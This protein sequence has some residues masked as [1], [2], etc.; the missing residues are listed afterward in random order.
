MI[1]ASR[2]LPLTEWLLRTGV[3]GLNLGTTRDDVIAHGPTDTVRRDAIGD[4]AAIHQD[5]VQDRISRA[6]VENANRACC[7]RGCPGIDRVIDDDIVRAAIHGITV[8]KTD[9]VVG[10]VI[11][12]VVLDNRALQSVAID[13]IL[14]IA[15]DQ[16]ISDK[17][18]CDLRTSG[19]FT[20][21]NVNS[22]IAVII[23]DIPFNHCAVGGASDVYSVTGGIASN[24]ARD[25]IPLNQ[26]II[27]VVG[28]NAEATNPSYGVVNDAI[29]VASNFDPFLA[30][31]AVP[32]L[33]GQ[34]GDGDVITAGFKVDA[35]KRFVVAR[36]NDDR[37]RR[38]IGGGLNRD[39][40]AR[41]AIDRAV[42]ISRAGW[43]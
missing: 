3:V 14:A 24:S 13:A 23:Y 36:V 37:S 5:V 8:V 32:V 1:L 16:V 41:S 12:Q 31:A 18:I 28:E 9:T 15:V 29:I 10:I 20:S 38:G 30:D 43:C 6:A 35:N 40:V 27:S 42:V 34:S 19:P 2:A 26:D 39:R 22:Y 7:A 17:G 21:V 4:S 11:D 25:C 33:D